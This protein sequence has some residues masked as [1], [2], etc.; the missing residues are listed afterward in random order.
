M[1]EIA[2][3]AGEMA[4]DAF[5][6]DDGLPTRDQAFTLAVMRK[7]ARRRLRT[8]L[9]NLAGLAGLAALVLWAL[10]PV[11]TPMFGWAADLLLLAGPAI[12]LIGMVVTVLL[13]TQ[14]VESRMNKISS[15]VPHP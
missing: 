4:L 1:S 8:E 15:W 5:F 10:S 12:G 6:A 3:T 14:P 9:A 7:A 13:V 11:L 2:K